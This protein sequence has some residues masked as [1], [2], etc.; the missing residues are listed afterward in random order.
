MSREYKK[1]RKRSAK[2]RKIT[3]LAQDAAAEQ[4]RN[5]LGDRTN[6]VPEPTPA[7]IQRLEEENAKL[8]QTIE[9]LKRQRHNER[10]RNA[11]LAKAAEA[12]KVDL[13]QARSEAS[14]LRGALGIMGKELEDIQEEADA[15]MSRLKEKIR[16]LEEA[17]KDLTHRRV[18]LW[19]RCRRLESSKRA[20][21][22]RRDEMRKN[23]PNKFKMK[24]RGTFTP[25]TRSLIRVMV[26]SGT[27][28]AKVGAAL[29]EI[30]GVLGIEI[31]HN[32]SRRS[33]HRF[34]VEKGVA[35]DI[36]L[37]YEILK[38]GKITYS[39]DSTSHKHIE[40]EC[41]TIALQVVNYDDPD[42]KLEWKSRTLGIGTSINHS[43][44]T[45]VDG[46]KQ[47]LQELAEIF[48]NSPLAKREHLRFVVDDFAYRLIGTSGDHAAD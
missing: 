33:A 27:A 5:P 45:Q 19:K 25:A 11:R 7:Q 42:A 23:Q 44:Q 16:Q 8:R 18:I 24:A 35:A 28:E 12:R 4:R 34:V 32:V 3:K 9:D 21:K 30:G 39:S 46:L 1:Q 14:R 43:S 17:R 10:R 47:R 38:A 40:Y 13:K 41:R 20:L 22:R 2:Q 36:Q 48:N 29:Q 6:N 31:P 26:A 15:S 37:V